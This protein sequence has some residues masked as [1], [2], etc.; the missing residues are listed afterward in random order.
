MVI[1]MLDGLLINIESPNNKETMNQED[2]HSGHKKRGGINFQG[3]CDAKL[4]FIYAIMTTPGKTDDLKA[5]RFSKLAKLIEGL[6]PGFFCGDDNAYV[7]TEHLPLLFRQSDP[8]PS[9]ACIRLTLPARI[10]KLLTFGTYMCE[11][12]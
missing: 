3:L 11:N 12:D 8:V 10:R 4:R 5:Y 2:Y 7:N 1:G 6:P 9:Y